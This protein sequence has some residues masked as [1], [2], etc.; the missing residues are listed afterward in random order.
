MQPSSKQKIKN[1]M[2]KR[3]FRSP[4]TAGKVLLVKKIR[5]WNRKTR[6]SAKPTTS[7]SHSILQMCLS[8][9]KL[10]QLIKTEIILLRVLINTI[11]LRTSGMGKVSAKLRRKRKLSN[12]K[13]C[14]INNP[15][16]ACNQMAVEETQKLLKK[17]QSKLRR[18]T[19]RRSKRLS[20]AK[21]S[22]RRRGFPLT[23]Y[24]TR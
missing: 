18:E 14:L 1:M 10:T 9:P 22:P 21:S 7:H 4:P 17:R 16:R 2:L 3:Q 5:N 24:L 13:A 12:L 15:I 23:N 19:V 8:N 20:P 11:K 6:W